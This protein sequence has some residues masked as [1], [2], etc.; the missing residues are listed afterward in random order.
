MSDYTS[1]S[2]V[3]LI[4]HLSKYL[5]WARFFMLQE[6]AVQMRFSLFNLWQENLPTSINEPLYNRAKL[7]LVTKGAN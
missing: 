4:L 5:V 7:L 3:I 2:I 6:L 1:L